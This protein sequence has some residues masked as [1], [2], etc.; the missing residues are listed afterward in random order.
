MV[1]FK[2]AHERAKIQRNMSNEKFK[3][4]AR[5]RNGVETVP[6]KYEGLGKLC[7]KSCSCIKQ[8]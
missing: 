7:P 5:L 6:L 3:N 4:Y 1:V 8:G 2:T